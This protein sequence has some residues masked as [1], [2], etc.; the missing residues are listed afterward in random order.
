MLHLNGIVSTERD[1]T[2]Y[3]IM[4]SIFLTNSFSSMRSA[5]P[6]SASL[7]KNSKALSPSLN[8]GFSIE[9]SVAECERYTMSFEGAMITAYTRD[10]NY[11]GEKKT[12]IVTLRNR[13]AKRP[14]PPITRTHNK[15]KYSSIPASDPTPRATVSS[16]LTADNPACRIAASRITTISSN[17]QHQQQRKRGNTPFT[18]FATAEGGGTDTATPTSCPEQEGKTVKI[19]AWQ[20]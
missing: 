10:N 20:A 17:L 3:T 7:R 12:P 6:S 2:T 14:R 9:P 1:S 8:V 16:R 15:Y 4:K 11:S 5:S 19:A 18:L 13:E